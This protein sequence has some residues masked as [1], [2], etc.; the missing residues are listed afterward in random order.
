M[1]STKRSV[2]LHQRT[3]FLPL[4]GSFLLNVGPRAPAYHRPCARCRPG[5][6]GDF[7][8]GIGIELGR[9]IRQILV[10]LGEGR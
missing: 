7:R 5:A 2:K 3:F 8:R 9:E 6:A 10:A 4:K 1:L